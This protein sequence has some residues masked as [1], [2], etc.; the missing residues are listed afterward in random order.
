MDLL[1]LFREDPAGWTA[2]GL[3]LLTL[4]LSAVFWR[5][6]WT[7]LKAI[8]RGIRAVCRALLRIR[9][10]TTG[11][12]QGKIDTAVQASTRVA[13]PTEYWQWRRDA[14]PGIW[15]LENHLGETVTVTE[16]SFDTDVGWS[17]DAYP[18]FPKR[19][20]D[21]WQVE[22]RGRI[23]VLQHTPYADPNPG[24]SVR[25]I[26]SHGDETWTWAPFVDGL[27]FV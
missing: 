24:A 21:G 10:T 1:K 14:R 15:L 19:T 7:V 9:V 22:L 20:R 25:W 4:L 2:I 17:W 13:E 23:S 27:K 6:T 5:T 12:I 3:T 18:A 8:G 16:V 26:D 11:R